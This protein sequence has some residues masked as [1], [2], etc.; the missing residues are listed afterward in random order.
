VTGRG[1]LFIGSVLLLIVSAPSPA[2]VQSDAGIGLSARTD[3]AARFAADR[4]GGLL[5]DQP[6]DTSSGVAAQSFPDFAGAMLIS[7]DDFLVTG[8]GWELHS[9]SH[10]FFWSP[11]NANPLPPSSAF[12]ASLVYA[13][14]EDDGG[15]P[16]CGANAAG[17]SLVDPYWTASIPTTSSALTWTEDSGNYDVTVDLTAVTGLPTGVS[18]AAGSYW[19][20]AYLEHDFGAADIGGQ[21]F[22]RRSTLEDGVNDSRFIDPTNLIPS[23]DCPTWCDSSPGEDVSLAFTLEGQPRTNT[24]LFEQEPD[25]TSGNAAQAFPDFSGA[26][27]I[28]ADDFGVA[29]GTWNIQTI[30]FP[31]FWSPSNA[32]PAPPSS[33]FTG[34]IHFVI[35]ADAGGQP[36]CVANASGTA[37]VD[38]LF[39]VNAPPEDTA[40]VWNEDSGNYEVTVDL[41]LLTAD[42]NGIALGE[43]TY[44]LIAYLEHDFGAADIG[45]Q[46]F[47]NR[48]TEEDG[49]N[50]GRFLDPN[51]L[52]PSLDCSAWCDTDP[53]SALNM[54][55]TL[56]GFRS[57]PIFSDRFQ[58]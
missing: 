37:L 6:G 56:S 31:F 39:S 21:I 19:M 45:G 46:I 50:D 4:S 33:Q 5:F 42:P 36:D 48:S 25:L 12:T 54:A 15:Q 38:P 49:S 7:S 23:D 30:H 29:N 20:I 32:N 43:G 8:V 24:I 35:C 26:L 44:W 17:S 52:I 41:T 22:W 13:I 9:I 3:V 2:S 40:L 58:P 14:C 51:N 18:L 16:A 55:F 28:T 34:N 1:F 11:S 27:L 53:G 47:W 57:G 10:S